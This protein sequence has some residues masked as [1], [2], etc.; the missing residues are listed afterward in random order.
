[1]NALDKL[2]K[3]FRE[4]SRIAQDGISGS[5]RLDAMTLAEIRNIANIAIS[6]NIETEQGEEFRSEMFADIVR[7]SAQAL[8]KPF[9]GEGSSWHDVPECIASLRARVGELE[10][11]R[12]AAVSDLQDAVDFVYKV[13]GES[14]ETLAA[15]TTGHWRAVIASAKGA[16]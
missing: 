2:L 11:E 5:A 14:N 3:N 9:E 1:M 15:I 12:D 6:E 4:I 16:K 8:G 7:R 10:R 13:Y